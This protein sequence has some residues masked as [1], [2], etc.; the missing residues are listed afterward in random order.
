MVDHAKGFGKGT[1]VLE[2]LE[3]TA[4]LRAGTV[5]LSL[6]PLLVATVHWGR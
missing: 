1:E 3:V 5:A 4:R 2:P 6:P